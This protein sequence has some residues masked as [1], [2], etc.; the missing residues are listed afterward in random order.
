M[1]SAR[2]VFGGDYYWAEGEGEIDGW[3]GCLARRRKTTRRASEQVY[4]D[5]KVG[6]G[7]VVGG[8]S[9]AV[10]VGGVCRDA[11]RCGAVWREEQWSD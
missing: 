4:V 5:C 10:G 1:R 9:V 7:W 6:G 11:V 2:R 8:E 3:I